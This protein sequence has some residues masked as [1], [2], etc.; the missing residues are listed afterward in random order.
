MKKHNVWGPSDYDTNETEW[1]SGKSEESVDRYFPRK[2]SYGER[3]CRARRL[4]N[5][6]IYEHLVVKLPKD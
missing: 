4:K 1:D 5:H 2:E 6:K 3:L